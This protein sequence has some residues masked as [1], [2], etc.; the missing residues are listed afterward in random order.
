MRS[1][2]TEFYPD[3]SRNMYTA[4]RN[5]F[6]HLSVTVTQPIFTKLILAIQL[7]TDN[8]YIIFFKNPEIYLGSDPITVTERQAEGRGPHVRSSFLYFVKKA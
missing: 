5:L 2:C 3:R 6:M 1:I 8:P 4:G 7:F